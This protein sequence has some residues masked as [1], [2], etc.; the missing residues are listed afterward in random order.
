MHEVMTYCMIM[1][2]MIVENERPD[3]RN[4]HQW[5]FKCELVAPI[6]ETSSWEQYLHM[7]VEVTDENMSRRLQTDLIEHQWA[8][9]GHKDNVN[10]IL[11]S[12]RLLKIWM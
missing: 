8:L 2:N 3:D 10:I 6:P 12:C 1:H 7:N 9:V 11:F 5:D 4:E